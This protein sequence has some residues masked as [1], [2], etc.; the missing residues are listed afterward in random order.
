MY[1][2]IDNSNNI[3]I[4]IQDFLVLIIIK[5]LKSAKKKREN[6]DENMFLTVNL[7][8]IHDLLSR[9]NYENHELLLKPENLN[10]IFKVLMEE[11]LFKETSN[12]GIIRA[13]FS[14]MNVYVGHTQKIRNKDHK[15]E[16]LAVLL[17]E[18]EKFIC[19]KTFEIL[20]DNNKYPQFYYLHILDLLINILKNFQLYQEFLDMET[21]LIPAILNLVGPEHPIN[22]NL[23]SHP[24]TESA[25]HLTQQLNHDL[26][27]I[28]FIDHKGK[29]RNTDFYKT[30]SPSLPILLKLI[31]S[32]ISEESNHI[33]YDV[34]SFVQNF[35]ERFNNGS[36]KDST[37]SN[38][39]IRNSQKTSTIYDCYFECISYVLSTFK[40]DDWLNI[41]LDDWVY[42]FCRHQI[43]TLC[44]VH[45]IIPAPNPPFMHS[46]GKFLRECVQNEIVNSCIATKC[47]E[48]ITNELLAPIVCS[49]GVD[50]SPRETK[51]L[52]FRSHSTNDLI[53]NMNFMHV[54]PFLSS[55]GVLTLLDNLK[56]KGSAKVFYEN[57]ALLLHKFISSLFRDCGIINPLPISKDNNHEYYSALL[58]TLSY[59]CQL[60]YCLKYQHNL[61]PSLT[62]LF[63]ENLQI[64]YEVDGAFNQNLAGEDYERIFTRLHNVYQNSDRFSLLSITHMSRILATTFFHVND[65]DQIK[66]FENIFSLDKSLFTGVV[67]RVA[68]SATIYAS[69]KESTKSFDAD[70][71]LILLDTHKLAFLLNISKSVFNVLDSISIDHGS[72]F[73]DS[74]FQIEYRTIEGCLDNLCQ[75]FKVA[76][77]GKG[78]DASA[79]FWETLANTLL[80]YLARISISLL[81]DDG[82]EIFR[83][84]TRLS[85][86]VNGLN[87][88]R[89]T[90]SRAE[91]N[92]APNIDPHFCSVY[93]ALLFLDLNGSVVAKFFNASLD[94]NETTINTNFDTESYLNDVAEFWGRY[95]QKY[96][97]KNARNSEKLKEIGNMTS[98]KVFESD[99]ENCPFHKILL[100]KLMEK[101]FALTKSM[102]DSEIGFDLVLSFLPKDP[103]AIKNYFDRS[104]SQNSQ[105]NLLNLLSNDFTPRD[106]DSGRDRTNYPLSDIYFPSNENAFFPS[107]RYSIGP[108]QVGFYIIKFLEHL[109]ERKNKIRSQNP[110]D[111]SNII[112]NYIN[113]PQSAD[114]DTKEISN[115]ISRLLN[116]L[117]LCSRSFN[118]KT[119]ECSATILNTFLRQ[120]V[121]Q[122]QVGQSLIEIGDWALKFTNNFSYLYPF[123]KEV[124]KKIFLA[125]NPLPLMPNPKAEE[126]INSVTPYDDLEEKRRNELNRYF[127]DKLEKLENLY[128]SLTAMTETDSLIVENQFIPQMGMVFE[129]VSQTFRN[130]FDGST[131][132]A[133]FHPV[134]SLLEYASSWFSN[135]FFL[136]L[137]TVKELAASLKQPLNSFSQQLEHNLKFSTDFFGMLTTFI[138][139]ISGY[140]YHQEH[141][142]SNKNGRDGND[143]GFEDP[144]TFLT[145]KNTDFLLCLV[146]SYTPD[147]IDILDTLYAEK[148]SDYKIDHGNSSRINVKLFILK[149]LNFSQSL[150]SLVLNSSDKCQETRKE[151]LEFFASPI[152]IPIYQFFMRNKPG[153]SCP[154]ITL[155]QTSSYL[156]ALVLASLCKSV[157]YASRMQDLLLTCEK[158]LDEIPNND[159]AGENSDEALEHLTHDKLI[160]RLITR[161]MD[162]LCNSRDISLQTLSFLLVCGTLKN[163]KEWRNVTIFETDTEK[164]LEPEGDED[165]VYPKIINLVLNRCLGLLS[166]K[167]NADMLAEPKNEYTKNSL[168]L[169]LNYS[170]ILTFLCLRTCSDQSL[171][172]KAIQTNV[173]DIMSYSQSENDKLEIMDEVHNMFAKERTDCT[174]VDLCLDKC[175]DDILTW[176]NQL[177]DENNK[178]LPRYCEDKHV[179]H[180]WW[181]KVGLPFQESFDENVGERNKVVMDSYFDLFVMAA[182]G[183]I[184][185]PRQDFKAQPTLPP[186][187]FEITN[188]N[189]STF[190]R[191]CLCL[192]QVFLALNEIPTRLR[193]VWSISPDSSGGKKSNRSK[194]NIARVNKLLFVHFELA[195]HLMDREFDRIAIYFPQQDGA[196][197]KDNSVAKV[198]KASSKSDK[199]NKVI[200]NPFAEDQNRFYVKVKSKVREISATYEA[201]DFSIEIDI[202][203]PLEYPL[204]PCQITCDKKS[205]INQTQW[206]TWLLQLNALII[207][208]DGSILDGLKLWKRNV[209]RYVKGA[210]SCMICFSMID[211]KDYSLGKN[212][213][214]QC[215]NKYHSTCLYKWFKTSHNTTCPLCRH[216]F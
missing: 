15:D 132:G 54:K 180:T 22:P 159:S 34:E 206:R 182:M 83:K 106:N 3:L 165:M 17:H 148:V 72:D 208:R 166:K 76:H 137:V 71:C 210:A 168:V 194:A 183:K 131:I 139:H 1:D 25:D 190:T 205:G 136:D 140:H 151:F 169:G 62:P 87:W 172:L 189:P 134:N 155:Q 63:L 160:L 133:L 215:K 80:S 103:S 203:L 121:F 192:H 75:F 97:N 145:R 38:S 207:Y 35:F 42:K 81:L 33:R 135:K 204:T 27:N 39:R 125:L 18:W 110:L 58:Q 130:E 162:F 142:N 109:E 60:N 64:L 176:S 14:I 149:F 115:K 89:T 68:T 99:E 141:T 129:D 213:C 21:I 200:K 41:F 50:K 158:A 113:P 119:N 216:R 120:C 111:T 94:V 91:P 146:V 12:E 85:H 147:V 51:E 78:D 86:I 100:I 7:L 108:F 82:D 36:L 92:I 150:T 65:M 201:D 70:K 57:L 8:S 23:K 107:I 212:T 214:P 30:L 195:K 157:Y 79:R 202:K 6:F 48:I 127:F 49:G 185:I 9:F 84:R 174:L 164:I 19:N 187:S 40:N 4:K 144:I 124:E 98:Q 177:Y 16:K 193:Q 105:W 211:P 112:V 188:M 43:S 61:D 114:Y 24:S 198:N 69:D 95:M 73:F 153:H 199:P 116:W 143:A 90:I 53:K 56:N 96:L 128:D 171:K 138:E 77:Q 28:N 10:V 191:E 179:L 13:Y 126:L 59:T 178:I 163:Y 46:F 47:F 52:R 44:N 154:V 2:G 5:N 167:T 55:I 29:T 11:D 102:D 26:S 175:F 93:S 88:V 104:L 152:Y 186:S 45:G 67:D 117:H 197:A 181:L 37:L 66:L 74:D 31:T 20:K 122:Y 123:G 101:M 173:N 196:T 118:L 184:L 156:D 209:D 32:I 161:F 170:V